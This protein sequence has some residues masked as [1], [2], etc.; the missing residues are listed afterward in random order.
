[1]YTYAWSMVAHM[2]E[3]V[4][5]PLYVFFFIEIFLVFSICIVRKFLIRQT[6]LGRGSV[7]LIAN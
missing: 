1:M 7:R 4:R 6:C 2:V 3:R 5:K